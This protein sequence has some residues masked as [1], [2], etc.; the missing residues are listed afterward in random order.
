MN[1]AFG[2]LPDDVTDDA[3]EMLSADLRRIVFDAPGDARGALEHLAGAA[4]AGDHLRAAI[5]NDETCQKMLGALWENYVLFAVLAPEGP[6]R[7]ILKYGYSEDFNP[8]RSNRLADRLAPRELLAGLRHPDRAGFLITT[9]GA[10]WAASFHVEIAMPDELRI[11]RAFLFDGDAAEVISGEETNVNRASLYAPTQ[12][13]PLADVNAYVEV[14][15]E[16]RGATFNAAATSVVV[17][18]LLWLGVASELNAEAP[19][20]AVSLLLAGAALFSGIAAAQHEHRLVTTVF[21]TA[22]RG[23]AVVTLCALAGSATLAMEYPCRH[24]VDVRQWA[25]AVSSLVAL[26]LTWSAVRAPT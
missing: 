7:R 1:A 19:G 18:A 12:V 10:S 2:A 4:E 14:A 8:M 21:S 25:A 20:A 16:R 15:P 9:P 3:S 13:P 26:R 6:A 24:P 22:R 5:W 11:E 23:L 17:T